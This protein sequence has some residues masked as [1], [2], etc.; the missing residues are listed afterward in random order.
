[1]Y[2]GLSN[3]VISK[4]DF[5]SFHKLKSLI[6]QPSPYNSF[7]NEATPNYGA[8]Q[9]LWSLLESG[10]AVGVGTRCERKNI[11]DTIEHLALPMWCKIC[12][13]KKRFDEVGCDQLFVNFLNKCVCI[14]S[15]N[16]Q[17]KRLFPQVSIA[18]N[19]RGQ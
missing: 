13:P 15:L 18:E 14:G 16:F 3:V 17:I 1:M 12:S 5:F 4:F 7:Y 6:F 8:A 9:C 19:T 11:F 2:W 10:P